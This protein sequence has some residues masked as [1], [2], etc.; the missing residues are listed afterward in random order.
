VS[1]SAPDAKETAARLN[2]WRGFPPKYGVD[3]RR[4]CSANFRLRTLGIVEQERPITNA[5]PL[6]FEPM[7]TGW[8][9]A[10]LGLVR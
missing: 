6:Y 10:P 4:F 7:D 2:T 3:S 5:L 1:K 8:R 9:M